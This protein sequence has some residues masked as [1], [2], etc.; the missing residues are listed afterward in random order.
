MLRTL[1]ALVVALAL[2]AGGAW[3]AA[4]RAAG[5]TVDIV[6]PRNVVGQAGELEILAEAPGGTLTQLDIALEQGSART[7]LFTLPGDATSQVL[8][9]TESRV[10]IRRPIG[11]ATLPQLKPG[12]ARLVVTA[13]RPVL[14]GY[15][16]AT[17]VTARDV[18]VRLTPP[19]AGVVSLHHFI[20]HGGSELVVYRVQPAE[21][22]SGV[23]VGDRFYPGFPASAAGVA[24]ADPSLKVA[25]FALPW[26]QDLNAPI[27]VVARDE[28]GNEGR[29]TFDH[30]VIPKAFRRSRIEIDDKFLE[31]VVPAIL[32]NTPDLKVDDPNDR[33]QA[34]LKINRELRQRNNT[35]IAAVATKSAPQRLWKGPFK[36]LVNT[37]V[38]SGFA[39]QRTYFYKGKEIDRQVHL[40][41]DLASTA[42]APVHAANSGRVAFADY[43]GIYGNCVIVDHGLGLQ[44][45]YAHLTTIDVKPGQDVT[46]GQ[47]LGRSGA[48]GLAGGD[49]LHFTMVL[50]GQPVTPIDWWSAQWVEDRVMRKLREAGA[51]A[52]S[53]APTNP[54]PTKTAPG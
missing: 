13:T 30:R 48:T 9:E 29:A 43:L 19:R 39:D 17:S 40:G 22:Q 6:K 54:S 5:P 8:Q 34:F 26:D 35:L 20:N 32:A 21:A 51:P 25:F 2:I 7:P 52:P 23:R 14:F 38:E 15:R 44:S 31:R 49:H 33:V 1:M 10:R 47:T 50:S 42:G 36:Q 18:D 11:R 24:G 41:F 12:K 16:E 3:F 4:G 27:A 53:P 46:Q 28:A 37:A 45:L